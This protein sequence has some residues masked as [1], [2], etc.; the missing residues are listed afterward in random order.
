VLQSAQDTDND[1]SLLY[2]SALLLGERGHHDLE[3]ELLRRLLAATAPPVETDDGAFEASFP[4]STINR[5]R[6]QAKANYQLG[7]LSGIGGRL[8]EAVEYSRRA[9]S[10]DPELKDAFVNLV[11]GLHGLGRH[12]EADSVAA[13]ARDR[14]Q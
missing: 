1:L 9:V 10:L 2:E 3:E 11:T 8:E 7:Y 5:R 12:Q 13:A 14:F 4:N 6:H